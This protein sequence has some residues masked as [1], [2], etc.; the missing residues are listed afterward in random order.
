MRFD[1]TFD[2]VVV[3]AGSAGC[4]IARR[5][6]DRGDCRV[7]LLEAG[8]PDERTAIHDTDIG[9]M[10]SMWGDAAG[11]LAARHHRAARPRRAH[12]GDPAGPGARRRLVR[13]RDDVRPWQPARLRPLARPRQ[14]RLGLRRRPA[15]LP[16]VRG[17]RRRRRTSTAASTG[18]CRSCTTS[19]P[20][21]PRGRSP[22]RPSSSGYRAPGF[23]YNGAQQEN[24]PFFYQST[25]EQ[26]QPAVEHGRRVP[27]TGAGAPEPDRRHRGA[28]HPGAARRRRGGRGRVRRRRRGPPGPR[29]GRGRRLPPAR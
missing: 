27:A 21:T 2:V 22:G 11:R 29:R 10:T 8:G 28:G 1:E 18:R 15:V 7:L 6:V 19:G 5:L 13:Q 16:P 12:R 26:G 20:P 17:L 4:V 24:G 23:D 3:G 14:R 9:S 25:R